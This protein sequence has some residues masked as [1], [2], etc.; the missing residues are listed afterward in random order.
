MNIKN[1]DVSNLSLFD[2][3]KKIKKN[4]HARIKGEY[5]KNHYIHLGSKTRGKK[6]LFN[7]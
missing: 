7:G 4:Y 1:T 5:R 2:Q 6:R 3:K